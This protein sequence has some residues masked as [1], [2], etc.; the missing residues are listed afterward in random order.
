MISRRDFLKRVTV[1]GITLPGIIGCGA[2]GDIGPN[3]YGSVSKNKNVNI[4][5]S[6]KKFHKIYD[7]EM[8][9]GVIPK[10]FS[11][12]LDESIVEKKD[13]E[14][15]LI[16]STSHSSPVITK[17]YDDNIIRYSINSNNPAYTYLIRKSAKQINRDTPLTMTESNNDV[18][19]RYNVLS[20]RCMLLIFVFSLL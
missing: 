9:R 7:K 6:N 10:A 11:H 3:N 13:L 1:A 4:I 5:K 18:N 2:E 16:G 19:V 20:K 15:M 8:L 17:P 12:Y 14:H